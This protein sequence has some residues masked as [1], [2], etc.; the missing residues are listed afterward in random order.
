M[1]KN[2]ST[3]TPPARDEFLRTVPTRS[4]ATL[5]ELSRQTPT[6]VVFL[7]HS[8][9]PFCREAL[10]RIAHDRREIEGAGTRIVLV[11]MLP[12]EQAAK[13]FAEY[14]LGDVDRIS[15]PGQEVYRAFGLGRGGIGQVMG[16]RTWWRG[17]K[18]VVLK[19][20]RPGRPV[21]DI[22]QLPG[23]FLLVDGRTIRSFRPENSSEL[24][25]YAEFSACEI[26]ERK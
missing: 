9:C 6:L 1:R 10:S 7:R 18:A 14:G 21:G 15:D 24:P 16:P 22:Y 23:V 3:T 2:T 12:D 19:G 25:N 8:G 20:H 13:F 26:P 11:H 5:E 17:F 4:G